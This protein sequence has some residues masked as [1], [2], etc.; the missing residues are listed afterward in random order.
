[1]PVRTRSTTSSRIPS[2]KPS[3]SSVSARNSNVGASGCC[4]RDEFFGK[5]DVAHTVDIHGGFREGRNDCAR[6]STQNTGGSFFGIG[7]GNAANR[8]SQQN[9]PAEEGC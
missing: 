3:I 2:E 9:V 8:E 4:L 5:C 6:T 7:Y 1:M